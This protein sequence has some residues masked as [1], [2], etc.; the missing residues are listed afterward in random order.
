MK[1][2][3]LPSFVWVI[4][5]P[6]FFIVLIVGIILTF[7]A[8]ATVE[9]FASIAILIVTILILRGASIVD[10]KDAKPPKDSAFALAAGICFFALMGIAIDQPGNVIYNKP[11]EILF[12]PAGTY[13]YRGTDISHPLPGRTDITQDFRCINETETVAYVGIGEVIV[14][15]FF[16]YVLIGYALVYLNR[17][18]TILL[19]KNKKTD[20]TQSKVIE[21][22]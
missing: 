5:I 8:L 10:F 15:R 18:I 4:L 21:K 17:L 3:Q 12:C 22:Y 16:E 9:G 7:T 19:L 2:P 13:L 20:K 11:I 6:I 14:T 1:I